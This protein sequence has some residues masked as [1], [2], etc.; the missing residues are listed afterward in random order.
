MAQ[1]ETK[2]PGA[3]Q[4]TTP[5][6]PTYVAAVGARSPLGLSALQAAMLLRARQG[7]PRASRFLDNRERYIGV[8]TA[9]GIAPDLFG[10]DRM[11]AL[12][13]PA[14]RAA[15]LRVPDPGPWPLILAVPEAARPDDDRR[16]D[17]PLLEALAA[18]GRISLDE[19]R[20]RTVRGGHAGFATALDIALQEIAKGATKVL[21]GAVDSYYHEAVLRWLDDEHRLHALDVENGFVPGE[22][23]AVL[24]LTTRPPSEAGSNVVIKGVATGREDTVILE[25][26]NLGSAATS[27][28]GRLAE[29]VPNH[30][31][32]W[33]L[34]DVNGE[35][36]RVREWGFASGRGA[37]SDDAVHARPAEDFG[38]VGAATGGLYAACLWELFRVKA[39]PHD[40]ACVALASDGA[41]RGAFLMGRE[42]GS[43]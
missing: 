16:L 35:R 41:E 21:V 19:A 7:Q 28:L 9:P 33:S 29:L 5:L 34:S 30:K 24:A 14:L 10:V 37:F 39:S 11:M 38:D 32:A 3:I 26:P 8:C 20:S 31:L 25:E 43:R 17:G 18:I 22:G 40:T 1:R 15:L 13:A 23:A 2:A 27:L 12:L 36:H 42:G 6:V 4:L